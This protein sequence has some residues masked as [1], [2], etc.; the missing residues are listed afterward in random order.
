MT[1]RKLWVIILILIM[2]CGISACSF[3]V[4]PQ[5]ESRIAIMRPGDAMM[6][7]ENIKVKGKLL[8]DPKAGEVK[9]DIGGW[10]AMPLNH[11][12]IVKE[13]IKRLREKVKNK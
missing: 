13:E 3:S 4:G 8:K 6:I 2:C 9:Q 12:E 7:T 5:V 1:N 10:M 11:W